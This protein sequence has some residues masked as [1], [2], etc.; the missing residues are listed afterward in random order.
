M[1]AVEFVHSKDVA[2]RRVADFAPDEFLN[3]L[4][5]DDREARVK[6]HFQGSE[7]RL[8]LL[9]IE[10]IPGAKGALHSHEKDEIFYIVE[11]ELQ[12]GNRVCGPGDSISILAGTL[13]RFTA[14]PNGCRYLKF[15][16]SADTS[17]IPADQYRQSALEKKMEPTR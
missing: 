12:F 14:G 6:S 1:K 11:G 3:R 7:N 2:S 9:E 15:T 5:K 16:G 13:Y 8:S 17:F 10:E 4:S